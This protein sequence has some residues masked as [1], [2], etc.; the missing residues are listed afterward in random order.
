VDVKLWQYVN[1]RSKIKL[2]CLL[3]LIECIGIYMFS[4]IHHFYVKY[5]DLCWIDY[6]KLFKFTYHS[7]LVEL[8]IRRRFPSWIIPFFWYYWFLATWERWCSIQFIGWCKIW[9][10]FF[11]FTWRSQFY[12]F[13]IDICITN[14]VVSSNNSNLLYLNYLSINPNPF[15]LW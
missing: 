4:T 3:N 10:S 11:S 1:Y 13:S 5:L 2:P 6:S 7:S 14:I 9:W 8:C 15:H 12:I